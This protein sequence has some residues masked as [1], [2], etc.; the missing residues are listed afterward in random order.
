MFD[1]EVILIGVAD[2]YGRQIWAD[3]KSFER[4]KLKFKKFSARK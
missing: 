2:T 3:N 1:D 4:T